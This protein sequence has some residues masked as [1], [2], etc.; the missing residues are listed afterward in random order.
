MATVVLARHGETPW[1]RERRI[2]GWAPVGLS[3]RGREQAAALGEHLADAYTPDRLVASDLRRAL[4]TAREVRRALDAPP[5]LERARGWRERDFGVLQG[6]GYEELF[7]TF[8][9]YAILDAGY[10]AATARPEGGERLIDAR[11]RSL[12][13]LDELVASLE[14]GETAVVVTHGGPV[15]VVL[16]ALLGL[17]LAETLTELDPCNCSVTALAVEPLDE[18][19]PAPEDGSYEPA[20]PDVATIERRAEAAFLDAP[21]AAD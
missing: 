1:N 18:L 16:G 9:E 4:E 3:E 5:E 10:V 21:A 19:P 2:Q 8:P 7:E 11:A 12:R 20:F 14:P 15:R 13:A 17:D 6:F